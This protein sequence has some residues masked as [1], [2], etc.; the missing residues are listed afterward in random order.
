MGVGLGNGSQVESLE[1]KWEVVPSGGLLGV[2][3]DWV[4]MRVWTTA[5]GDL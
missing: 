4:L 1:G 2:V 3:D 5:G